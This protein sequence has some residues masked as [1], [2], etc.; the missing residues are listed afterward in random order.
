[1]CYRLEP[2]FVALVATTAIVAA[3]PPPGPPPG[4]PPGT[5]SA[6][7]DRTASAQTGT[8]AIRGRIFAAD[9][10]KPLRRAR[11]T[12]TAPEL[13]SDTRTTS[14]SAEGRYELKDL[15]AGR[16]TIRVSR[17]GYL[18]LQY[19]QRRPLEQGTPLQVL[20][21]Q[22]VDSVDFS[23]PRSATI[24]GRIIDELSDPVADV[25][26]F[27][28]RMVYFQG[29]R[30]LVPDNR[31]PL[32]RTDEA[33]EFRLSGLVPGAYIVMA[34]LRETWT[35]TENGIERTLGYAPTYYPGTA[36]LTDARRVT[37]EQGKDA[38]NVNFALMPGRA[39]S[40]S[41]TAFDASG[42][43]LGG[44]SVSVTQDMSGP[45]GTMIML[46]GNTTTAAD[47]TFTIRNIA[48]GQY[49]LR[50]QA[51]NARDT[52]GAISEAIAM[53]I[54]LDGV[55]LTDLS[56]M[57]SSGWSF[58]GSIV[59]E[60]G[61]TPDA[62]PARFRITPRLVDGDTN[63]GPPPPPAGMPPPPGGGPGLIAENGRVRDDWT[64]TVNAVF[65]AAHVRATVPDGWTVKAILHDG[66]DVADTP[67]EMRSGEELRGVQ[68]IV[69]N[70][71]TSVTGQLVDSR[72]GPILDATV[73]V[74]ADDSSKWAEESRWVR[75][76][77]P[78]QQGRYTIKGL[79]PG[80]YLAAAITYVE[81]GVWNDPDYLD[82]IRRYA[83]KLTLNEG[84]SQSPALRVVTP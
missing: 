24:A 40:I 59:T 63:P 80:E 12:A 51:A 46:A 38:T 60:T 44:R 78:D 3:Q 22:I 49:R 83:E 52:R 10:G 19:G 20:D 53:P 32:V 28:M 35:V 36:T 43:P 29:R 39:A 72:G 25:Q 23:L 7:R 71:V 48:P 50:T 76:V 68:V 33:G 18:A 26:V 62:A 34:I 64:F 77:R 45:F 5:Q 74:F 11:I 65:G 42:A 82:S 30:R 4:G 56:L 31:G 21:R 47:G 58:G 54:V 6:P 70:R 41:G 16:Y 27:P 61:A 75:A 1:M 55:D 73:I 84:E 13:G 8:A 66:R 14:T 17:S 79:P 69:S 2:L 67:L 81:D 37:V 15:P 9:S 57:T